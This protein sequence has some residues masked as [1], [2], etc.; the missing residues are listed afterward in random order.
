MPRPA[1]LTCG[2]N[3]PM[4]ALSAL[5]P[6]DYLVIGH[7]TQDRT[8]R[9]LEPG[10]TVA[11][12]AGLAAA[13]GLR[14]GVVTSCAED[15]PPQ[16]FF[17]AQ[18]VRVPAPETTEFENHETADGRRQWLHRRA[19]PLGWDDVPPAWRRTRLIHLAPVA[20][21]LPRAGTMPLRGELIGATPQGWL[22]VWDEEGRVRPAPQRDLTAVLSQIDAAVL[23]YDD[24]GGDERLVDDWALRCRVLALTEGAEGVRLYWNGDVRYFRPPSVSAVDPTGAGDIFAAAFFIRLHLTRDPWEAARF[25]TRLAAISVTRQGLRGVPAPEEIRRSLVEVL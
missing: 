10:G 3:Y 5:P 25:A 13:L 15:V 21:E 22:R 11:Y 6:I 19:R 4:N 9:G 2:Y 16:A 8:P 12:A 7:V 17:G 20:D 14:V 1:A 18:V 23:S 24:L